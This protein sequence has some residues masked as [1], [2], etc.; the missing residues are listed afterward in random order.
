MIRRYNRY[1]IVM[2]LLAIVGGLICCLFA[3]FFFRYIPAWALSQFGYGV[4]V[5][6]A[7]MIGALGLVVLFASG[8]SVWSKEGGLRSYG[9]SALY[10]ESLAQGE[11][12]GAYAVNHYLGRVTGISHGL[13][14]LFLAGPL[15]L[16]NAATRFASLISFSEIRERRMGEALER[17]RVA[18]KWQGL[19]EHEGWEEEIRYLAQVGAVDFGV[20]KGVARFKVNSDYGD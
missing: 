17:L 19:E 8:Y 14:Q 12:G 2:G 20:P 3:Y 7:R 16:F 15:M 9:E 10:F 18:N 11:T 5:A 6:T 4:S 1:Q 13:S